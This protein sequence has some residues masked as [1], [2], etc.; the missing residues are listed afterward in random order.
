MN[1][2]EL[3]QRL[4]ELNQEI[5][6]TE[7]AYY[8]TLHKIKEVEYTI[9]EKT[10]QLLLS[11]KIDG[12]TEKIRDAQLFPHMKNLLLEKIEAEKESDRKKERYYAKKREAVHIQYIIRLLTP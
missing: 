8:D 11:G 4:T 3:I 10:S 7:L 9:Q 2:Q 5:S 6:K 12:K 1:N